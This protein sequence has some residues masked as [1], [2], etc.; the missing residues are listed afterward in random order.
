MLCTFVAQIFIEAV[1]LRL[2]FPATKA[3][4]VIAQLSVYRHVCVCCLS[5]IHGESSTAPWEGFFT[6][7]G[8]SP[9]ACAHMSINIKNKNINHN[10][11]YN[12]NY[13][14][15]AQSTSRLDIVHATGAFLL[16]CISSY[17]LHFA[18][19]FVFV[20]SA[21][22]LTARVLGFCN[23]LCLCWFF[24]FSLIYIFF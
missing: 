11:N 15:G 9:F 21:E 20:F 5:F 13:K 10:Y 23:C 3:T 1:V 17:T 24:K 16:S 8:T 2:T 12:Y 4:Q 18:W 7:G 14:S 22:A 19:G 6:V